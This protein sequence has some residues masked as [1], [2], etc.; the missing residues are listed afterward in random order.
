[1]SDTISIKDAQGIQRQSGIDLLRI[2]AIFLICI[3]HANQTLRGMYVFSPFSANELITLGLAPLG[4]VGNILFVVC[5]SY[6]LVDK[7]RSRLNKAINLLL[8]STLISISILVSFLISKQPL[9]G[10]TIFRQFFPDIY[11]MNWFVPC[12]V[13]FYLIAP[14]VVAGLKHLTKEQHLA[15]LLGSFVVYGLLNVL[16]LTPFGS[17]LLQFF[18]ILNIV[19]FI[20]WHKPNIYSHKKGNFLF[21]L[22]GMIICYSAYFGIALLSTKYAFF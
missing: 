1:M 3:S 5:S 2:I 13:I 15:I 12:Y 8:D 21:F 4:T 11:R 17:E 10:F 9:D 18:Y 16:S 19:A 22:I 20:K 7:N 6:F 14:I